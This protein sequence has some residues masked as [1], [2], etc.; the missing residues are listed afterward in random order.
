MRRR[1]LVEVLLVVMTGGFHILCETVFSAKLP[2]I[3]TASLAWLAYVVIRC[4]ENPAV[5]KVWGI[6]TD[7]LSASLRLVLPFLLVSVLAVTAYAAIQHTFS[8]PLHFLVI[9]LIYPVWGV[10][11]QFLIQAMITRN[12][13]DLG[14]SRPVVLILSAVLF[15]IVHWPD[16]M[17]MGLTC[18]SGIAWSFIYLK[19]PN[20][21]SLG[22]CHGFLG[23]LVY[24]L[25][26][27]RDPWMELF[28]KGALS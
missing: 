17:L 20:L 18:V 16:P 9:A 22:V 6:R 5:L 8:L 26:L 3:V 15:G 24:Y 14:W 13:N 25:V 1:A 10:V 28:G 27:N 23:A 4:R 21:I 11:Q 12:L 2:F 19:V 7:N